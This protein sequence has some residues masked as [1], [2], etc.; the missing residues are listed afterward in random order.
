MG[1]PS[2]RAPLAAQAFAEVLE[3]TQSGVLAFVRHLIGSSDD[4]HDAHDVAQ[5]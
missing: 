2:P 1:D 4:A 5:V 3:A